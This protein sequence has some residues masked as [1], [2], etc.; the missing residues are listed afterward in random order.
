MCWTLTRFVLQGDLFGGNGAEPISFLQI[1]LAGGTS[2][3]P[4]IATNIA[5]IFDKAT[6]IA[7]STSSTSLD[8]STLAARGAAFQASLIEQFDKE[9][10]EQ[11]THPVCVVTP[12]ITKAIGVMV[13]SDDVS[14]GVFT[15]LIEREMAVPCRRTG[16]F[17][18]P[19]AGGDV[20]V[21]ICEGMRDIKVITQEKVKTNGKKDEDDDD[22]DDDEDDEDDEPDVVREKIWKVGSVLAEAAVK[23]VKKGGKVEVTLDVSADMTMSVATREV[24]SKGGVR[25]KLERG[26][27]KENGKA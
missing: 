25:G 5:R 3:T 1:V 21:K 19:K 4:R 23:N 13:V 8:P 2:H 7:P 14:R 27:V 10:I 15:P 22:D 20:L 16:H 11:S 18:A 6:I 17:A 24:G 26:D 9:D 12:H